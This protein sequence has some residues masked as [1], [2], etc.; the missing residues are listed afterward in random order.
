MRP[1]PAWI[2]AAGASLGLT[3]LL[4]APISCGYSTG[5]RLP[6]E[7]ETVGV[8]IFGNDSKVPNLEIELQ[9]ALTDSV[10]RLVH[11]QLVDPRRADLFLRG[12]IVDYSRRGG[13]RSPDN[14]LLESGVGIS[15]EALLVRRVATPAQEPAA[16]PAARPPP[17]ARDDRNSL[18][19]LQQDERV[20]RSMRAYQDFGYLVDQTSGEFAARSLTLENLADRIV[21]ELFGELALQD[22]P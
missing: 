16:V 14:K 20:V 8:E 22:H 12:R 9:L 21:L 18:P 17:A 2:L 11:A 5:I 6:P 19:P 10:E 4:S 13:I 7:L 3:A 1:A 15:V